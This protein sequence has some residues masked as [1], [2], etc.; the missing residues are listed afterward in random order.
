MCGFTD[1]PPMHFFAG[2]ASGA[3]GTIPLQLL[4]VR[5]NIAQSTIKS[6]LLAFLMAMAHLWPITV[7]AKMSLLSVNWH[8]PIVVSF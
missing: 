8:I 4:L 2:V 5:L 6:D 3:L 1:V 7:K